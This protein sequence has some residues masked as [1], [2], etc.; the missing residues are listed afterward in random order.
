MILH[1]DVGMDFQFKSFDHSA[2]RFKKS[3]VIFLIP[4]DFLSFI[5]TGQ[6]I[7]KRVGIVHSKGSGHR[8]MIHR[9]IMLSRK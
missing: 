7:V 8:C 5:S 9:Y 6:H 3:E 1:E 2:K 4:E